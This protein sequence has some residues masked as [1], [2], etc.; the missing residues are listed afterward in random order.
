LEILAVI[1]G[2]W[3]VLVSVYIGLIVVAAYRRRQKTKQQGGIRSAAFSARTGT[4]TDQ[5]VLG[6][7]F[8]EVDML[9]VQVETLRSEMS[10]LNGVPRGERARLRRY[11]S[12]QY[13]DLPR[14]LRRQVRQVREVR[15]FRHPI[16]V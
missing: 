2:F 3:L 9:R 14:T 6:G 7:L 10:A 11:S 1:V 4:S 5:P 13:T 15:N 12:G 16:G 8:S